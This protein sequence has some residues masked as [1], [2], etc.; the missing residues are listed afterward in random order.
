[1]SNSKVKLEYEATVLKNF[2]TMSLED[3][4]NEESRTEVALDTERLS[5]GI[6]F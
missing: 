4:E 6:H 1:M 5:N 3:D 2:S